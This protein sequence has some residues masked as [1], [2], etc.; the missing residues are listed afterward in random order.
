MDERMSCAFA[1]VF[2]AQVKG[3]ASTWGIIILYPKVKRIQRKFSLTVVDS[4]LSGSS[5]VTVAEVKFESELVCMTVMVA[6]LV[7]E[8]AEKIMSGSSHENLSGV[9]KG[10]P[11]ALNTV[12]VM[13]PLA[14]KET[15]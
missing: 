8:F 5:T 13:L 3:G 11:D 2:K 6:G 15:V 9:S 12:A 7:K 14:A 1:S 10:F 4:P